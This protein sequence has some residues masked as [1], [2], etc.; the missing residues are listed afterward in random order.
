MN[1][2]NCPFLSFVVM[3]FKIKSSIQVKT[4]T[5]IFIIFNQQFMILKFTWNI[6][7][8]L[9]LEI[10]CYYYITFYKG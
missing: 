9:N 6:T 5:T 1:F 4:P 10:A 8:S 3:V 7:K 2:E